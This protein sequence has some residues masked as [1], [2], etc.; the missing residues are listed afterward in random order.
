[1]SKLSLLSPAASTNGVILV[2]HPRYKAQYFRDQ[3]WQE[4]WITEALDLVRTEW[5]TYYK[6]GGQPQPQPDAG[7]APANSASS[8]GTGAGPGRRSAQRASRQ[9]HLSFVY[10]CH[11]CTDN[12]TTVVVVGRHV[13]VHLGPQQGGLARRP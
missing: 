9:V 4:E 3:E 8:A 6:P 7:A 11:V 10:S 2:M 5:T 13:C 12:V 1:M